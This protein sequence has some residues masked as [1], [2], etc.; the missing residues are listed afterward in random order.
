ML[1]TADQIVPSADVATLR[2]PDGT[3]FLAY[4][5]FLG[6]Q[7]QSG[8]SVTTPRGV[9][10]IF[11]EHGATEG[12]IL[13]IAEIERR[14]RQASVPYQ[15]APT[16]IPDCRVSRSV[17]PVFDNESPRALKWIGTGRPQPLIAEGCV[18]LTGGKWSIWSADPTVI[19]RTKDINVSGSGD[20]ALK[21]T[22][23]CIPDL[24]GMWASNTFGSF[25]CI[26]SSDA[27]WTECTG[28]LPEGR[29]R[30]RI[31]PIGRRMSVTGDLL[32]MD[33]QSRNIGGELTLDHGHLVGTLSVMGVGPIHLELW[34]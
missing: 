9:I 10:G 13:S 33:Q 4:D 17:C 23:T 16:P 2:K 1:A 18:T 34:K 6:A 7:G 31:I 28:M 24:G 21:P 27:D 30:L 26:S 11:L 3:G 8:A 20:G 15:L 5:G 22:V 14:A 32:S 25:S 19:C 12:K 29:A